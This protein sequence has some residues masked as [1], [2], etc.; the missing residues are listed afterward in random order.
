[1]CLGW[2]RQAAT[3]WLAR[4]PWS[5]SSVTAI[6]KSMSWEVRSS[7]MT[8]RKRR[9]SSFSR[10]QPRWQSPAIWNASDTASVRPSCRALVRA[11]VAQLVKAPLQAN[12]AAA[13][14]TQLGQEPGHHLGSSGECPADM[15]IASCAM[16][17]GTCACTVS[18]LAIKE[19]AHLLHQVGGDAR[20]HSAQ[21]HDAQPR[22]I[23][24]QGSRGAGA[25]T[26]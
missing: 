18:H 13:T 1:M 22:R 5:S 4:T 17:S 12:W 14:P 26:G 6:A 8:G 7:G 3:A 21:R 9:C 2:C 11:G 10:S 19:L 23:C 25:G 24:R 20:R 15:Q 16:H